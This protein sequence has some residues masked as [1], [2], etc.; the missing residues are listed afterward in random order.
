[1]AKTVTVYVIHCKR[2]RAFK[3]GVT[4]TNAMTRLDALQTGNPCKLTI[5]G[6]CVHDFGLERG[7]HTYLGG[8]RMSGEWFLDEGHCRNIADAVR[9]G[10]P[11][12]RIHWSEKD[13]DQII[14]MADYDIDNARRTGVWPTKMRDIGDP[15]FN[16]YMT[17]E[18]CY[19]EPKQ[20]TYEPIYDGI[21]CEG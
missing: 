4:T 19:E 2:M 5:Y 12:K 13:F 8:Y 18:E 14:R 16:G 1:M 17:Q 10:F 11:Y 15:G 6:A 7:I 21:H 20:L 3:F 9:I